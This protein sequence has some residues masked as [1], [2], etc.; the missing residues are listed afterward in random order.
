M[1]LVASITEDLFISKKKNLSIYVKVEINPLKQC[2]S[3][4]LFTNWHLDHRKLTNQLPDK[5]SP[6]I[7][8][9]Y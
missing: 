7:P 9:R 6:L 2:Y 8:S 3:S 4:Y 1:W 5:L